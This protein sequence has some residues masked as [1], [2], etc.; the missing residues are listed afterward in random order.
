MTTLEIANR[1]YEL[2]QKGQFDQI[3]KELYSGEAKSIE[4][5]HS[6]WPTVEG[7]DKIIKKSKLWYQEI[8][9]L[10]E[11]YVTK[12]QVAGKYFTCVLGMK[13]LSKNK[14]SVQFD[15]VGV[16]QEDKG[17]IISEQFFY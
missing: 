12:L 8:E 9:A 1:F 16:Y 6:P 13:F 5:A 14:Q 17:K 2:A 3:H 11:G 7:L 10:I 4:P 15:E